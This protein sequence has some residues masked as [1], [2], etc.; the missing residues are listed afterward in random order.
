MRNISFQFPAEELR[1]VSHIR[2]K[3][4]MKTIWSSVYEMVELYIAILRFIMDIDLD[5]VKELLVKSDEGSE[6]SKL[7]GIFEKIESLTKAL[8]EPRMILAD[9]RTWF[10]GVME[11]FM[12][13]CDLLS[14]NSKLI[15][16]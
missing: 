1:K 5:K 2:S 6:I 9:A 16:N 3:I 15:G 13:L 8:Q 11:K 10:D 14:N 7:I 12:S 4:S